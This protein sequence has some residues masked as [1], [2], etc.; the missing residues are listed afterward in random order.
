MDGR[1]RMQGMFRNEDEVQRAPMGIPAPNIAQAHQASI[2][3]RP[4]HGGRI[5]NSPSWREHGG[6][7]SPPGGPMNGSVYPSI[8]SEERHPH[9]FPGMHM[10]MPSGM[11]NSWMRPP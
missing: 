7:M 10:R 1:E 5:F 8:R 3:G 4:D 11:G 6:R 2:G 9:S